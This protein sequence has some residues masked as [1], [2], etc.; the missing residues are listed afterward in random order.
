MLVRSKKTGKRFVAKKMMLD[1]LSEKEKE[2]CSSEATLLKS[3]IHPN[4]VSYC[5]SF[6]TRDSLIIIM[7]YCEG[8]LLDYLT[9]CVV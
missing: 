3:L 9:F 4:I 6:L 1:G 7:E 5:E 8:K 2:A